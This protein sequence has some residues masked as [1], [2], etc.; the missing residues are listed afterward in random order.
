MN[1]NF[2]SKY[3]I[4]IFLT[5]FMK[6]TLLNSYFVYCILCSSGRGKKSTDHTPSP[7]KSPVS[8]SRRTDDVEPGE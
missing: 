7:D 8:K 2:S 6:T 5:V 1:S 3:Q 4:L